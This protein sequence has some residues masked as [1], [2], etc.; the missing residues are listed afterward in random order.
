MK[1]AQTEF[2]PTRLFA[3]VR[4]TLPVALIVLAVGVGVPLFLRTPL[5]CDVTLYDLAARNVLTGGVHYRDLFDTNT[6]GFVWL[7]AGIR[8]VVGWSSE[9]LRAVDLLF[10]TGTTLTLCRLAK[11]AGASGLNRLWLAAGCACFYLFTHEMAHAQRDVWLAL[12]AFL[13][14]LVRLN[15][16]LRPAPGLARGVFLPA[17]LEGALWAVAVWIKPHFLA[18]AACWWVLTVPRLAGVRTAGRGFGAWVGVVLAD[19]TGCLLAGGLIGAAGVWYLVAS[20]TWAAFTEVMTVWN[21]GYLENTLHGIHLRWGVFTWF[22]PWNFLAPVAVVYAL[23]A[24]LDARIWS[25]RFRPPVQGGLLR[26][27]SLSAIWHKTGTDE[28]RYARACLGAVYVLWLLQAVVLQR[29]YMYIHAAEVVIGLA[30]WAA[31]RWNAAALVLGWLF[32]IQVAWAT[33]PLSV[34]EF[35]TRNPTLADGFLP[36]PMFD[37][38]RL[39]RWPDCFRSLPADDYYR[40][41]DAIQFEE[42]RGHPHPAGITWAEMNEVAEFLRAERVGD[43]ELVCWHDSPHALYLLLD[44]KP[45]LR[46]MH[47]NTARMISD[48]CDRRVCEEFWANADTRFVVI[49]LRRLAFVEWLTWLATPPAKRLGPDP[50]RLYNEPGRLADDTLPPAAGWLRDGPAGWRLRGEPDLPFPVTRENTVFRSGGTGRYVV[51]RLKD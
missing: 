48:E 7:L 15:R 51:I 4:Q 29:P 47:V 20:G 12:P 24:L 2:V 28:Q 9:G 41:Q 32:A 46:F 21:V 18:V 31:H 38:D 3:L 43:R 11:L 17:L 36:H 19:L 35:V 37:P 22:P 1:S 6:P 14:V 49:D 8:A 27:V 13:A 44:V 30:V 34:G 39:A 25:G 10:F 16:T 50:T 23:F 26:R 5:W 45:G 42:S 40:R 33:A